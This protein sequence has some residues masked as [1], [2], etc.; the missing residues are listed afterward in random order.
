VKSGK[1]ELQSGKRA[2]ESDRKWEVFRTTARSARDTTRSYER[3]F[4]V[5][6]V[7]PNFSIEAWE[8]FFKPTG[9]RVVRQMSAS[10]EKCLARTSGVVK[11]ISVKN[12]WLIWFL[13]YQS[14]VFFIS[15]NIFSYQSNILPYQSKEFIISV[16][17]S[18]AYQSKFRHDI[19]QS[20]FDCNGYYQSDAFSYQLNPM[21][22]YYKGPYQS[23]N[24]T[25]MM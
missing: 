1:S 4:T 3:V 21:D 25:D 18:W 9:M 23:K 20:T 7:Q 15:V 16:R 12:V 19:S 5:C 13:P 22:W 24:R 6:G 8:S 11:T 2:R 17:I 14:T 10:F